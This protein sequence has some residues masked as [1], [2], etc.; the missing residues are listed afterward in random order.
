MPGEGG[1]EGTLVAWPR[2]PEN[3]WQEGLSAAMTTSNMC[4]CVLFQTHSRSVTVLGP[5]HMTP[6]TVTTETTNQLVEDAPLSS[7]LAAEGVAS[8]EGSR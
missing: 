3:L 7:R 5:D 6:A 2:R 1:G 4:V 8:S